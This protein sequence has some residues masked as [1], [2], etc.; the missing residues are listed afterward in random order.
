MPPYRTIPSNEEPL[1]A[2][3]IHIYWCTFTVFSY[4]EYQILYDF[5]PRSTL[6][7][8]AKERIIIE[9]IN[10]KLKIFKILSCKYRNRRRRY[11]LRVNLLAA[12]YNCELGIGIAAS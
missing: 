9:H 7:A 4:L 10:R 2:W 5:F 8:L 11:S 6:L 3:L 12:I 1:L